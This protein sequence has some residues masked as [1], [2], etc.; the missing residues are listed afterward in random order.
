MRFVGEF[1]NECI[2]IGHWTLLLL[3]VCGCVKKN[4][5]YQKKGG[6]KE[7]RKNGEK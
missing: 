1:T 6:K 2:Q 4:E 5:Q 7:K 3:C